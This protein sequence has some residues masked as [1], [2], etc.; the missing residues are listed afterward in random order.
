MSKYLWFVIVCAC[1]LWPPRAAAQVIAGPSHKWAW[2]QAE[3][4]LAVA[5]GQVYEA[6][7]DG[8]AF[9]PVLGVACTGATSPFQCVGDLPQSLGEG[10]HQG[11]MRAVRVVGTTRNIS[12]LSNEV[13]FVYDADPSAPGNLTIIVQVAVT[14]R[15]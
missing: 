13:A 1:V 14:L 8:G 5:Q 2:D 6:A 3:T 15:K 9:A 10:A 4:T 12:P 11:R 7:I